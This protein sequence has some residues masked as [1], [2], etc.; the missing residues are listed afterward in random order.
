METAALKLAAERHL[1]E[2]YTYVAIDRKSLLKWLRQDIMFALKWRSG[3]K[4]EMQAGR[5]LGGPRRDHLNYM[6]TLIFSWSYV[7]WLVKVWD[8]NSACRGYSVCS[9]RDSG[10]RPR[11]NSLSTSAIYRKQFVPTAAPVTEPKQ[12]LTKYLNHTEYDQPTSEPPVGADC[13]GY[14]S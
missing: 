12:S 11:D 6:T 2:A 9:G 10:A 8:S 1:R 7:I 13:D 3:P 5:K 14:T 4:V